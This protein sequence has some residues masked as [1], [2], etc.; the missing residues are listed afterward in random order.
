MAQ[1]HGLF[2]D[3]QENAI[4]TRLVTRYRRIWWTVYTLERSLGSSF[5]VPTGLD[6]EDITAP[7]PSAMK[8]SSTAISETICPKPA[9]SWE[10]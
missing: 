3:I 10:N 9:S 6:D 8:V 2:T 1:T 5:G 4:G 7:Y